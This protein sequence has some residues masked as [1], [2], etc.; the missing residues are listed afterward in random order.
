MRKFLTAS[1]LSK[2]GWGNI[3]PGKSVVSYCETCK[4]Q[5]MHTCTGQKQENNDMLLRLECDRCREKLG[6]K[7]F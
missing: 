4:A 6:I 1:F 3:G 5:R 2:L 7:S